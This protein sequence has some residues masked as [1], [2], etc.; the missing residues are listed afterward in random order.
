MPLKSI[1]PQTNHLILWLAFIHMLLR[2]LI[3]LKYKLEKNG[4][5]ELRGKELAREINQEG[6]KT[7]EE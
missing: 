7:Y 2:N 3:F 5:V 4:C 6:C 1:D